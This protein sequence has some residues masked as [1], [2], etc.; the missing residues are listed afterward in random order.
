MQNLG[1]IEQAANER[2]ADLGA[3]T[4]TD[5]ALEAAAGATPYLGG[6]FSVSLCTVMAD[7]P[8]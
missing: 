7:C 6:A 4:I 8:N 1:N 5:Q 3:D 2:E